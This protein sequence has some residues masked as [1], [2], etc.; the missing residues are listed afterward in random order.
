MKNQ[1]R[2]IRYKYETEKVHV[3]YHTIQQMY[4]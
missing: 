1:Y 3:E 2:L 4:S